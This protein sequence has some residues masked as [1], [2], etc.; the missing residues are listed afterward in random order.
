EFKNPAADLPETTVVKLVSYFNSIS[1]SGRARKWGNSEPWVT[2]P[3]KEQFNTLD[4]KDKQLA[5]ARI[6]LENARGHIQ[7]SQEVWEKNSAMNAS[8]HDFLKRG[9]V[10]YYSF[11]GNDTGVSVIKGQPWMSNGISGTAANLDGSSQFVV[12][13]DSILVSEYR[14]SI[15][16]WMKPDEVGDSVIISRQETQT[17]RPGISAELKNGHLQFYILTRWVAGVGAVETTEELVPGEWRHV[18]LTNDGSQRAGGIQIFLDGK[19]VKTRELFNSNSNK[20]VFAKKAKFRVGGGVVGNN[21]KGQIDELRIYDRTL[22]NDEIALLA[23]PEQ[24]GEIAAIKPKHR[25][26]AAS[27]KLRTYYLENRA[28][29]SHKR[30]ATAHFDA[31]LDRLKFYDSLPTSMVME[32]LPSAKETFVRSRGVYHQ[33][34]E[35][36]VRKLPAI[37]PSSN[38]DLP[39]NRLGFAQWL[40]SGE[41]PLTGRVAVNR[42]WLKYFGKGLVK[43][44]EDFG[45]QGERPSH[46]ELLDW[47]AYEFVRLN[48]NIKAMQKLIVTSATYRQSS[49][50]TSGMLET[51]P[52]N[53]LLTRGPRQ[54]LSAHASRDQALAISGLL[55]EKIGGPSVNPYQP[56][57]FWEDLSNMTYEQSKGND[58]YRRSL[59]TIWKRTI[60]PPS[61]AILDAADRESC[62]VSPKRTNTPLQALTMLNEK[63]FVEA[64]RNFGQR[65]L[66]EGGSSVP[67]Q[68]EFAFRTVAG[69][70]PKPEEQ[71]LLENAYRDYRDLYAEDPESAEKLIQ[72]GESKLAE[73]LRPI[74]LAA[75]TTL[76]NMLLNLDEVVTKE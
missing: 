75:A 73:N 10:R 64:A 3:T 44:A 37:F 17:T 8:D 58:L 21:F 47:L 55:V 28:S 63:A 59:Y 68:V 51:D 61:M 20:D 25:S 11:D 70:Y 7:D 43:T 16:F 2:A 69:R 71:V 57:N 60:P 53:V 38:Q 1:E 24:V 52:G 39:E 48:W 12:E 40:V 26:L 18:T 4:Q 50:I 14:F 65:I 33:L 9:L 29:D 6:A 35:K 27:D 23:V 67:E 74:E 34:G 31:R 66:Q 32:E 22:W 13:S 56:D 19:L 46:P 62:I 54:R 5:N 72:V 41:H 15:S 42:Y 76:A 36:V 45:I 49:R 30:L